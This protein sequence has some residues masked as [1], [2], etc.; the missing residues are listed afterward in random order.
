MRRLRESQDLVLP[1][2]RVGTT[3]IV[4]WEH[5]GDCPYCK[6]NG[7]LGSANGYSIFCEACK[8]FGLAWIEHCAL[9][10]KESAE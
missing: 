10:M 6:G 9:W 8:G 2:G 4:S 5:L 7:V 1:A 3:D